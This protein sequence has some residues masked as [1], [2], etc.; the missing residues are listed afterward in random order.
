[1]VELVEAKRGSVYS[2][3]ADDIANM[4]N[5]DY[6]QS[7]HPQVS[8]SGSDMKLSVEYLQHRI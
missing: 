5:Q 6:C 3:A 2:V 1:M 4:G 7:G 8:L